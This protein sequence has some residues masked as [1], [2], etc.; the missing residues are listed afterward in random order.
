MNGSSAAQRGV[1][2]SELQEPTAAENTTGLSHPQAG[3]VF[4]IANQPFYL[5]KPTWAF[6]FRERNA[7]T[8]PRRE[9]ETSKTIP[10]ILNFEF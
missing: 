5:T 6:V 2:G 4:V 3:A 10:K 1:L 8:A 7:D 9:K